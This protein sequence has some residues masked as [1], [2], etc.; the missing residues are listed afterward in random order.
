MQPSTT[1]QAYEK[2]TFKP[3]VLVLDILVYTRAAGA[4]PLGKTNTPE[5]CTDLQTFNDVFG[6]TKN[7]Y[8]TNLT[9]TSRD[10][11]ITYG[12]IT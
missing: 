2:Q 4:V 6:T 5:A 3:S 7:P 10:L 8:D 9:G 11:S 12:L 1:F